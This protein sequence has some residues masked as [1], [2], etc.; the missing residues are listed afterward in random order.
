[1]TKTLECINKLL[2]ELTCECYICEHSNG[3]MKGIFRILT[4]GRFW[5]NVLLIAVVFFLILTVGFYMLDIYTRHG[6]SVTVPD[7]EGLPVAQVETVLGNTDMTFEVTDSIYRDDV[8]RGVVVS[9]NP[10][11]QKHV[12]R[13]RTIFLT[14]NSILPEMVT[15]PDLVGKSRRIALPLIEIAGLELENLKYRPDDS[16]TDC[17]LGMEY[18]GKPIKSGDRI[19]KGQK[20]TLILGR[21]SNV[22]TIVPTV[23][24]MNYRDALELI[25]SQS[26]NVGEILDCKGCRTAQDTVAAFVSSQIPQGGSALTLGG[27]V[28]VYLT[29]DS[30]SSSSTT[31]ENDP[32]NDENQ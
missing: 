14:V 22:T 21:Q 24:G 26:L 29:T 8:P 23:V 3:F 12:K 31:P 6:E 32:F 30:I 7:L 5:R 13:G 1:M 18:D 10:D 19:R 25:N 17:V 28:D 16:C 15:M 9:Q 4:A 11:A 27:Y 2:S 20:V